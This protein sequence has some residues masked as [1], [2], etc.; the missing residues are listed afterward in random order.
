MLLKLFHK[1]GSEEILL[2]SFHIASIT[3]LPKLD[4]NTTK[5]KKT[6]YRSILLMNVGRNILNKI[7][8][9]ILKGSYT[10]NKLVS[11]QEYKDSM[12]EKHYI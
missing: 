10:M 11:F 4:K 3:M 1:T 9:N 5:K 8:N 6:H 7:F 2:K 12:N